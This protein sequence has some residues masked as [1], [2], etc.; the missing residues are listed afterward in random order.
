MSGLASAAQIRS[1]FVRWTIVT[2]PLILFLGSLSGT[3]SGSSAQNSWFRTLHKPGLMPEGWAFGAVWTVL[4][5]LMGLAA[6][7][8][9]N[10]RGAHGRPAALTLFGIQLALHLVWSPLFFAAHHIEAAFWLIVALFL[11][12]LLP[13]LAFGPIP[14]LAG[15]GR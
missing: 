12:A 3:I 11:F 7:I 9:L 5:V 2:I 10:A 14:Q 1:S 4:Y 6:A 8:V 13:P 15:D